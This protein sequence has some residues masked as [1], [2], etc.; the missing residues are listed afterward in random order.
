VL[1]NNYR[2]TELQAALLIGQLEM[3]PELA[4]RR[5]KSA[6]RLSAALAGIPGVRPLPPQPAI[7]RKAIYCYVFQF[8][9]GDTRVSRDMF[10][11]ALDAEG[12]PS[13]GRFSEPVYR[14]DLFYATPANCPQL[15]IGRNRPVDYS[16]EAVQ[17]Q[18]ARRTKK[19]CGS[20]NSC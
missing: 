17:S 14:S 6:A 16:A 1:G 12:I 3:L 11:A 8:K 13:D 9:P 4:A 19:R 18:S 2:M 20:R 15:A 10:C 5:A 7:T